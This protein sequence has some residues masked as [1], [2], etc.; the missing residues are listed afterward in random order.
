[1]ITGWYDEGLSPEARNARPLYHLLPR[2]AR[3][4]REVAPATTTAAPTTEAS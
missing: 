4:E 3:R 2:W 1:M